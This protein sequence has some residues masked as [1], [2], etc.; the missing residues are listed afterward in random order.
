MKIQ[1]Y[2]EPVHWS[3]G[4]CLLIDDVV[5]KKEAHKIGKLHLSTHLLIINSDGRIY[6]R[7]R[8]K[9]EHRYP[10]L[11]TTSIGTHVELESDYAK[12]LQKNLPTLMN[13]TWGGE[14]RVKDCYENEVCGLY[15]ARMEE[16]DIPQEIRK[17][18]Y[19][20]P[21]DSLEAHIRG[22]KT[23]PH[24]KE[25]YELWRKSKCQAMK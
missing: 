14:F 5:N 4:Q 20:L 3:K 8:G 1:T 18:R 21:I 19:F 25:A 9:K 7:L 15:T 12:T 16:Y 2:H 24:L 11:L 22:E 10:N 13:L 17:G 23:T 6:C